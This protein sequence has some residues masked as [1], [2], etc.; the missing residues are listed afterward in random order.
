MALPSGVYTPSEQ[1][2]A[3]LR[4][5]G[6]P[7]GT[8]GYA[9]PRRTPEDIATA[10]E[11][12]TAET[13]DPFGYERPT[14]PAQ[15]TAETVA[16]LFA[17]KTG[18][19]NRLPRNPREAQ[20]FQLQAARSARTI[21][22]RNIA[23]ATSTLRYGLGLAQRSS[24]YSLAAM[25]SPYLRDI[26]GVQQSAQYAP[27][28]YSYFLRPEAYEGAGAEQQM[29]IYYTGVPGWKRPSPPLGGGFRPTVGMFGEPAEQLVPTELSYAQGGMP[30]GVAGAPT[31]GY[32]GGGFM[33]GVQ[34]PTGV[35]SGPQ[36]A[37]V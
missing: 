32:G 4:G 8:I 30:A 3:T 20:L 33:P 7:Y 19:P 11:Q 2:L 28:D 9:K 13:M 27:G 16:E 24:P 14:G 37:A 18:L 36:S 12:W 25:M 21:Q 1:K 26:A 10:R 34:S 5:T 15:A 17:P 23:A 35:L 22:Q 6:L 31:M 29:D